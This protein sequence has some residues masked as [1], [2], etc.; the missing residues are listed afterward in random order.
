V[1]REIQPYNIVY[2]ANQV[3]GVAVLDGQF[4]LTDRLNLEAGAGFG[5]IDADIG[6]FDERGL[7]L[8][9]AAGYSLLLRTKHSLQVGVEYAPVFHGGRQAH[10]V[11]FNVGFQFL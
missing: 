4:W 9:A 3:S 1:E 5:F 10:N 6:D 7:G 2:N 8:L 11:S